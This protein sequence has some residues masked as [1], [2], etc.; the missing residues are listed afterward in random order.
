MFDETPV[1]RKVIVPWYDTDRACM[2]TLMFLFAVFLFACCGLSAALEAPGY[3]PYV[4]MPSVLMMFSATGMV[5]V[6]LRVI[7][8]NAYKFKK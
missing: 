3:H 6:L 1:F 5:S 7:R 2:L 4:W 8:R